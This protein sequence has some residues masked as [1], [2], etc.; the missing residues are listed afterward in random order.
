M[1]IKRFYLCD[2]DTQ[3]QLL[4]N[5]TK[6]VKRFVNFVYKTIFFLKLYIFG[7][8]MSGVWS[9]FQVDVVPIL[10]IIRGA[11]HKFLNFECIAQSK[12]A[13]SDSVHS[14]IPKKVLVKDFFSPHSTS[15]SIFLWLHW[16]FCHVWRSRWRC[17]H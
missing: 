15:Y 3:W 12:S 5:K 10:L 13:P 11:T 16:F 7:K 2:I 8:S 14:S 4:G 9:D 6:K 17:R 1:N